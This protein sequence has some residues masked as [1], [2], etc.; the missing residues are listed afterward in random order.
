M[1]KGAIACCL[2]D[3]IQINRSKTAFLPDALVMPHF[4]YLGV[5]LV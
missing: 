4:C 2:A 1:N 5:K 3:E